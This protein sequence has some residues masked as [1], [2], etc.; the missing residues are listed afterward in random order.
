MEHRRLA[1]KILHSIESE[2]GK[3]NP[4]LLRQADEY[5]QEVLGWKGYAPWLYV[6]SA[7]AERF[8]EGWI[9]DNYYG[10]VVVPTMKGLH[11]KIATRKSLAGK[12]FDTSAFPNL[13]YHTNGLFLSD[14]Y[15][16][17]QEKELKELLFAKAKK[18]VFKLDDSIQ[19][20]GC[21]FWKKPILMPKK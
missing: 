8:Q 10:K 5:A 15:Q 7:V 12:L 14:R 6:Y 19:G 11:G 2:R 13:A 9:P 18:V 4:Q 21:S 16:P 20:K 3:T 17:L 1:T